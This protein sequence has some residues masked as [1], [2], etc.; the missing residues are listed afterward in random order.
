MHSPE[1]SINFVQ[2]C[3]RMAGEL[4]AQIER[5]KHKTSLFQSRYAI[6]MGQKLEAQATIREHESTIRRL[7]QEIAEL[8]QQLEFMRVTTVLAPSRDDIEATRTTLTQL[9]REINRCIK[10]LNQ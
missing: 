10:D 6:L 8:K 7:Q 2:N 1:K 5:L 3:I 4:Q 9:V